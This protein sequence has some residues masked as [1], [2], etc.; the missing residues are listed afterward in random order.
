LAA[1][2]R[3]ASRV[4]RHLFLDAGPVF[5]PDPQRPGQITEIIE[6][7]GV[8]KSVKIT[9]LRDGHKKTFQTEITDISQ[10]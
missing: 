8:G 1:A 7:A 9:T 6:E 4:G 10:S 3:A 2:L 5:T